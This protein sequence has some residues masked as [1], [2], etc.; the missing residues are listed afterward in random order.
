[1]IG[2][3]ISHYQIVEKLGEGGMGVV[4]KAE[5]TKLERTVALKFLPPDAVGNE[6]DKARFAD[7]ARAAAALDHPNICTVYEINESDSQHYIA[8]AFVEG[9]SLKEKIE[10]RPIEMN[11]LL[12]IAAQVASGLNAAHEKGIVHRDIKSANIMI[13]PAGR[14]KIMDFGLADRGESARKE[15]QN[16]TLGTVAYSSPEQISGSAMDARTDIWSFGVTLYEM[17]TGR[18]PFRGD[19]EQAIVYSILNEPPEPVTGLRTGVP[20]ELERIIN[21]A[22]AKNTDER[23]LHMGEML[24]DLKGLRDELDPN[25]SGSVSGTR[26]LYDRDASLFR[27][28]LDRHVFQVLAVYLAAIWGVSRLTGWIVD[29]FVLSPHWTGIATVALASLIPT[30]F[31]LAYFRG[32]RAQSSWSRPEKIGIPVNLVL[33]ATLLLLTFH[34]KDI[35]AATK[36]VAVE[37]EDGQTIER[38]VP[39]TEFRK[40]LAFYVF[41]N[42]SGDPGLDWLKYTIPLLLEND[43]VQDQ[44]L[45]LNSAFDADDFEKLKAAG[46]SGWSE[47]PLALKRKFAR[48]S[49]C[50]FFVTGSFRLEAGEYSV[51]TRLHSTHSG[52]VVAQHTARNPDLFALGDEISVQIRRDMGVPTGYLEETTDLT[53]EETM[54]SSVTAARYMGE[55]M[56]AIT[57]DQDWQRSIELYESALLEDSTLAYVYFSLAQSYMQNN[58]SDKALEAYE[59]AMRYVYKMPERVQ[60]LLKANYYFFKRQPDKVFAVLKMMVELYPTDVFG[61]FGL[62]Q[63]Y[64]YRNEIDKAIAEYEIII[65]LNPDEHGY[66]HAAG[67]LC[68]RN[69]DNEKALMYYEKFAEANPQ[70]PES[71]IRL[72]RFFEEIGEYDDA[73]NNYEKALLVDPSLVS[74]QV[75]LGDIDN[76]LGHSEKALEQYQ[77]ALDQS[78]SPADEIRAHNAMRRY[79]AKHGRLNESIEHMTL[80]QELEATTLSPLMAQL[81]RVSNVDVYVQAGR[82]DEAFAIMEDVRSQVSGPFVNIVSVGYAQ[83]YIELGQADDAEQALGQFEEYIANFQVEVLRPMM[84]RFRGRVDELR[85]NYDEAIARYQRRIEL[86]PTEFDS[87]RKIGRCYRKLEQY[88]RAEENLLKMLEIFPYDPK[89]NYELALVYHAAGDG[90]KALE[91]LT[92]TLRIWENADESYVPAREARKTAASWETVQ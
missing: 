54:T 1:M 88:D 70:N 46:F 12:K 65:E 67:D 8:M 71:F 92:R 66:L 29:Q 21:K 19:Y 43:M 40:K 90:T 35:G 44:F 33:A 85:G 51:E 82:T 56:A 36:T 4:Y 34:G 86:S 49:H 81:R 14:A 41:E 31:L 26:P 75:D 91:H 38:V 52:K 59:N 32:A 79:F 61:H 6:E 87:Y 60:F 42:D 57:F 7:E 17:V 72:G 89:A 15:D 78:R 16:S 10:E 68:V 13:T 58:Q 27:K 47:S 45:D 77:E 50:D 53:L 63:I 84:H 74:V 11:E 55:A 23:Y 24:L 22:M 9:V 2:K 18:L 28:M 48:E 69:G 25:R 83:I 64:M 76:K 5:D 37:T 80:A 73:R 3:K 62:A 20:V 39:K 30:V